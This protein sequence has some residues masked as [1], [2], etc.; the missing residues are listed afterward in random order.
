M[1]QFH[2]NTTAVSVP[3]TVSAE[4]AEIDELGSLLFVVMDGDEG[5]LVAAY[6]AGVWA[7]FIMADED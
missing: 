6:A 7:S 3:D 5:R 1:K 4:Y 2:V